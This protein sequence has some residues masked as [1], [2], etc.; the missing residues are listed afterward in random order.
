MKTRRKMKGGK[1]KESAASSR[2]PSGAMTP[3]SYT[4]LR[5]HET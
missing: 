1:D 2:L 5:A 4:H 3:V